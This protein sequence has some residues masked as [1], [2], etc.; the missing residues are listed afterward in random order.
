[1]RDSSIRDEFLLKGPLMA[2]VELTEKCN[3]F[4]KHCYNHWRQDGGKKTLSESS[5]KDVIQKLVDLEILGVSFTG[6]EPLLFDKALLAGVEEAQKNDILVT[7]NTNAV[8]LNDEL[9]DNFNSNNVHLL[10]SFHSS[11]EEEFS[12]LTGAN[13]FSVVVENIAKS[14]DKGLSIAINMVVNDINVSRIE[15]TAKFVYDEF[16]GALF[17][18]TPVSPPKHLSVDSPYS[19]CLDNYK[20]YFN[21]IKVLHQK[22]MPIGTLGAIPFC[23]IPED[24]YGVFA[25]FIGCTAG[26]NIITI[27]ADGGIRP[28]SQA[29]FNIANIH[30]LEGKALHGACSTNLFDWRDGS[31][32]PSECV[33]CAELNRCHA[34]CRMHAYN[35]SDDLKSKDPRMT[36]PLKQKIEFVSNCSSNENEYLFKEGSLQFKIKPKVRYRDEL[37]GYVTLF[38]GDYYDLVNASGFELFK[39]FFVN[40]T[41]ISQELLNEKLQKIISYYYKRGYIEKV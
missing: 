19:L 9:I 5:T 11:N 24:C 20:Q 38:S 40:S 16:E 29:D 3:H 34:G 21:A 33:D 37:K 22:G 2:Q 7:V 13:N 30:E 36:S 23:L 1:M 18:I 32:I 17:R 41:V 14:L 4:C 27:G 26:R 28:C 25:S 35:V 39:H 31:F 12:N 10:V 8:L 6:G 15:E